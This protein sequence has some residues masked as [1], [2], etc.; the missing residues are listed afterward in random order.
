MAQNTVKLVNAGKKSEVWKFFG[1][2]YRNDL[3]IDSE[4]WYCKICVA[5][6]KLIPK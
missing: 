1:R 5:N 6:G 2:L 4:H 3:E